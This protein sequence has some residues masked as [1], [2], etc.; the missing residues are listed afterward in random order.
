MRS[1]WAKVAGALCVL[2]LLAGLAAPLLLKSL[3]PPEK[4]RALV[5]DGAQKRLGRQVKLGAVSLGVL[6][7]LTLQDLSISEKPDFAAGTFASTRAFRLKV[8][9]APLLRKQVVVDTIEAE[10]LSLSVLKGA[11]GAFNFSDLAGAKGSTA[12]APSAPAAPAGGEVELAIRTLRLADASLLYKE[13]AAREVSVALSE[14]RVSGFALAGPFSAQVSGRASGKWDGRPFDGTASFAG[15]LDLGGRDPRKLW[16]EAKSLEAASK[17]WTVKASGRVLD[18]TKPDVDVK[19]SASGPSGK[20]ADLSFKGLVTLPSKESALAADGALTV[21]TPGLKAADAAALGAPLGMPVPAVSAS[22]QLSYG[23]DA[24]SFKS[25]D[26][27]TPWGRVEAKGR[28]AAL[29]SGAPQPDVELDAKLD[30]PQLRAADAPWLKL[31]PGTTVP[32]LKVE[33]RLHYANDAATTPGL[34]IKGAFGSLALKGAA[35]KLRSGKPDVDMEASVDADLPELKASDLPWAKLPPGFVS[36]AAKIA[37]QGRL[38]GDDLA[39]SSLS[40]KTKAGTLKASGSVRKLSAGAG[41][42][43]DLDL[44]ADLSLPALKSADIPLASVPPDLSLPPSKWDGS[45]TLSR[46]EVKIRSLRAVIG[47]NDFALDAGRVWQ[48]RS[49]RPL[50]DL[51]VKCRQFQLEELTSVSPRTRE[52]GLAGSGFFALGASGRLP[53][54]VLEGKLQFKGIAASVGPL[55]LADFTGTAAFNEKRIDVPNL[56]GKV[57]DG[58]LAMDLTIKNYATAPDVDLQASLSRFDLGGFFAARASVA[59]PPKPAAPS[60][61]PAETAATP[62]ISARGRFLVGELAHPNLTAKDLKLEWDLTGYTPDMR[63]LNGSAK[64][65]S[66]DGR[67]RNLTELALQ[68]KFAKIVA[69]PFLVIQRIAAVLGQGEKLNDF[70]YSEVAGDYAFRDGLMTLRDTHLDGVAADF[71]ATGDINLPAETLDLTVRSTVRPLPPL[72]VA[73]RGTVDKPE[74]KPKIAKALGE[75]AVNLLQNILRK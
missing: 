33:G 27:T 74:A 57:G 66:A 9:L 11:D 46:D 48:L 6:S 62:P 20:V 43:P 56:R 71:E 26:V 51:T 34:A 7:G 35:R 22:S 14:A 4:I 61:K 25:L 53:R 15:R 31:P 42:E 44:T 67:L 30:L 37:G 13:G 54:P 73:V 40:V 28:V 18:L 50:V 21:K 75:G 52:L 24:V 65:H 63:K 17:G 36:P 45:L 49:E 68:S 19:L 2:V 60:E 23:G 72:E 5:V 32:P 59:K 1:R 3:L 39:L 10:G 41:A 47:H 12:A 69:T 70:A 55:K 38:K 58:D 64:F 8:R 16:V 29:T